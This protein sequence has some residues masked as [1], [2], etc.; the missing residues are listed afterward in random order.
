MSGYWLWY[1]L[2][3]VLG[4]PIALPLVIIGAFWMWNRVGVGGLPPFVKAWLRVGRVNRLRAAIAVNPHDRP[5]RW[6]LASLLVEQG[7]H[8]SA[9]E[10]IMPN[11]EA[12]DEDFATLLVAGQAFAGSNQRD[13]A[14]R[15]FGAAREE[16][17]QFQREEIDL[18]SGANRAAMGDLDGA[19]DSLAAVCKARPGSVEA[20]VRLARV[21]AASGDEA[22]A[23]KMM[24]EAWNC[25]V[26]APRFQRR[27]D[28]F[29]AWRARP[30]RPVVYAAILVAASVT[31]ALVV[32]PRLG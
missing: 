12:G 17:K 6:E 25:Y 20:R 5:A 4:S 19:K 30:M 3:R 23:A 29:W 14:E 24:D 21:L 18:L 32:A 10:V 22:G 13:K 9:A 2:W 28:R 26:H 31:F 7:R 27:R 11:L 15:C 16:G 8:G 1:Y